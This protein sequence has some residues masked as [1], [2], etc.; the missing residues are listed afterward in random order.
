MNYCSQQTNTSACRN[1][2]SSCSRYMA[3]SSDDSGA[4]YCQD[5]L[6]DAKKTEPLRFWSMYNTIAQNYC[7]RYPSDPDCSCM[8]RNSY[9]SHVYQSLKNGAPYNDGCWFSDCNSASY[10]DKFQTNE[11]NI[12]QNGFD[13]TKASQQA[14]CPTCACTDSQIFYS[15]N[16][17]NYTDNQ[18]SINCASDQYCSNPSPPAS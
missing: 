18:N 3:D 14:N 17:V 1:G 6:N 11:V 9:G 5:Y 12:L 15:D 13:Y 4:K 8:M 16:S 7:L 2:R 10:Q